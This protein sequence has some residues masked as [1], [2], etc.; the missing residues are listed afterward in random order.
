MRRPGEPCPLG[1]AK[2]RQRGC[3]GGLG[4]PPAMLAELR[5]LDPRQR[6]EEAAPVGEDEPL[7]LGLGDAF[8]PT[9][10]PRPI[11]GEAID[12]PGRIEP[13]RAR[14]APRPGRGRAARPAAEIGPLLRR[15]PWGVVLTD[16]SGF[17]Q[18]APVG[19]PAP[20]DAAVRRTRD[21]KVEAGKGLAEPP[22]GAE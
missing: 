6:P 17:E 9:E 15:P 4:I 8:Q 1:V 3:Q 7:G 19:V 2:G 14:E 12:G 22:G 10:E 5:D 21:R 20:R 16:A 18:P 11:R 13:V